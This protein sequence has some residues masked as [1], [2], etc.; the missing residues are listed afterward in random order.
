[1]LPG[2]TTHYGAAEYVQNLPPHTQTTPY[3]HTHSQRL[4]ATYAGIPNVRTHTHTFKDPPPTSTPTGSGWVTSW[5][6]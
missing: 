4:I 5:L 3:T 2:E 1:M 6:G